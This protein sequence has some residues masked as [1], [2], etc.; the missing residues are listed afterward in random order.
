VGIVS[1]RWSFEY[2]GAL[3]QLEGARPNFF[4]HAAGRF[5][6]VLTVT[7][8]AG[9]W[10]SDQVNVTVLDVARP[11]ADAG[12][13]VTVDQHALVTLDGSGSWDNSGIARWT[14]RLE[15]RGTNFTLEGATPSFLFDDAGTYSAALTVLDAAGNNDTDSAVITVRDTTLPVAVAGADVSVPQGTTVAFNGSSSSDNV[16]VVTWGWDLVVSG[17]P[18]H[19]TGPT[20]NYLLSVPGIYDVRLTVEDAAGN[21]GTDSLV[22]RVN[23]TLAPVAASLSDMTVPLGKRVR[24]NASGSSDNVGI[25]NYTWTIRFEGYSYIE[26][27]EGPVVSYSFDQPGKQRVTL[28]VKDAQGNTDE[29]TFTVTVE[30]STSMWW[31]LIPIV[32]ALIVVLYIVVRRRQG[33]EPGGP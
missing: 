4:F 6:V 5:S 24:F 28:T 3:I 18:V 12:D 10:A 8:R 14:W 1:Y 16:G 23:D 22:V 9:N 32:I 26:V 27:L 7:D 30:E 21:A 15:Y 20:P 25:V 19:L 17:N 2:D 29:S 13:D 31:L 11:I 33:S